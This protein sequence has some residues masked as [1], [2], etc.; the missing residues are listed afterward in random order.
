MLKYLLNENSVVGTM[1]FLLSLVVSS[2]PAQEIQSC[3]LRYAFLCSMCL[4][5]ARKQL[6]VEDTSVRLFIQDMG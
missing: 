6:E 2:V 3:I 1:L 4:T 5:P